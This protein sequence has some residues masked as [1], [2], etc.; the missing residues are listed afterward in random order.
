MKSNFKVDNQK[1]V[2]EV[3]ISNSVKE[4]EKEMY[5]AYMSHCMMDEAMFIDTA[6]MSS[7]DAKYMCGMSYKKD[8][9]MLMEG[10]GELTDKQKKLPDGL[11]VGILKR[12]EKAG[13][14]SEEGKKQ[15]ESLAGSMEMKAEPTAVFVEK[16]AP[17]TGEI[18]PELA[19]EGLE[20]DEKLKKEQEKLAPKD[21]GLQS[22]TF[23]PSKA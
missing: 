17:E 23:K 11:K 15:L 10:A 1:L 6:G 8:R 9:M 4:D 21:P 18:N 16:P 2:A 22:P 20:I 3:Y 19:K 7:S 12:Y 14:L 13:T 5:T